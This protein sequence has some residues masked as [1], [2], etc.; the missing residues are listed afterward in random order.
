MKLLVL[1]FTLKLYPRINIF[2]IFES[3]NIANIYYWKRTIMK[4][5]FFFQS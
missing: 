4:F 3:K 1:L 2:N 5:K